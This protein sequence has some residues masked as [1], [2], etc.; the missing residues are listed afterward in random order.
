MTFKSDEVKSLL[1]AKKGIICFRI[2][3]LF[4]TIEKLQFSRRA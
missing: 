2:I 1:A 3:Q 4:M